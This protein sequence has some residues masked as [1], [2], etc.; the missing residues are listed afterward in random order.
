MKSSNYLQNS[1]N[2]IISV[3]INTLITISVI[4]YI[5]NPTTSQIK[6]I[7]REQVL[8]YCSNLPAD[9]ELKDKYSL[10][11]K[12]EAANIIT[13]ELLEDGNID[14]KD[15]TFSTDLDS[16]YGIKLGFAFGK[17]TD[18]SALELEKK[19][20]ERVNELAGVESNGANVK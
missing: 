13:K 8:D 2:I 15:N 3:C 11:P 9:F 12:L 14:V 16:S 4:A 18:E 1:S 20:K 17:I 6:S 5:T 10:V 7:L 19:I